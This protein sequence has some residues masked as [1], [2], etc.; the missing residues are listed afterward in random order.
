MRSVERGPWPTENGGRR[1][2]FA[3]YG[4]RK[5]SAGGE[6]GEY[7][8]YCERPGDLHVE[9]VVLN[10]V[11][12]ELETEW[13]DFLLA[14]VNCSSRKPNGNGSRDRYLWPDKDD[15]FGAFVYRSDGR[16]SVDDGLPQRDHGKTSAPFELV[17]LGAGGTRTDRRRHRRHQ[18]WDQA[19]EV[20]KPIRGENSGVL[21][22]ALGTGLFSVWMAM[23]YDDDDMRRRLAEAFPGTRAG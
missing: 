15:T 6:D 5:S 7:C 21:A 10:S 1:V 4:T 14:C 23:F 22:V 19:V 17:G 12:G 20:R 16:M 13:S 3:R 2:S 9:H 11:P 8:S 18:A